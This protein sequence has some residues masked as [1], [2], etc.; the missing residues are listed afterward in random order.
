MVTKLT[1]VTELAGIK[2]AAIIGERFPLTAKKS[3]TTLYKKEITK[4]A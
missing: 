4:L 3:P 2:I 1:T